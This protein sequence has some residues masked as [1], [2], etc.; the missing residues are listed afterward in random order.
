MNF[1][2]LLIACVPP[3]PI[4]KLYE[5][6]KDLNKIFRLEKVLVLILKNQQ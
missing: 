6:L 5:P 1:P 4:L 2:I 3:F